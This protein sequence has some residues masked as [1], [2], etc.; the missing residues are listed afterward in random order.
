MAKHTLKFFP[1][2]NADTTLIKL[3]NGKA[4]LW[5]YANVGDPDN[6]DDKRVNLPEKL[7]QEV[8]GDY[9]TVCFTHADNDHIA[10][11]SEYFYLEHASK[12][13]DYKRKKIKDL[14]VPA[15]VL[16]DTT[17]EDEAKVLKAE[18][19]YRLRN[20]EGILV[21]SR[22]KQLKKWCDDQEDISYDDVKHLFVDAGTLVLRH[23]LES[24]GIQFFVHSPFKS[25]TLEIDR[26]SEAIV[27]QA[28][29][30]DKCKTK[31]ILGSDC[32][33]EIWEDIIKVTRHFENDQT[34]GWDIFHISHHCSYLSLSDD[35]GV[36]KTNP[37]SEINW[38]YESQGNKKCRLVSSSKTI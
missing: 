33:W 16:L 5:D 29:F 3:A 20:K 24:D 9:D 23:T 30:N 21:F 19:R 10:G 26:N 14:W 36:D 18:A 28:T 11:F 4:I 32:T 12:Y 27:V 6:K 35:K 17:L 15:A 37:D 13:Q 38:L 1:L 2:G 22:P 7:D 8:E 31:L 25:D 34:L